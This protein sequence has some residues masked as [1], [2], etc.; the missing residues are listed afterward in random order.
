MSMAGSMRLKVLLPNEILVDTPTAKIVA[1]A[2]NGAF[3]LLPRHID[4]VAALAP[5]ILAYT[6]PDGEERFLATDEGTL[7]KRGQEVL[8]SVRDAIAGPDLAQLRAAVAARYQELD[9]R[10]RKARSALAHLEADF[11]RRFMELNE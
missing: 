9:E 8:V 11:V 10:E 7:V 3:C 5:G 1:E 4:F 2:E 6:D